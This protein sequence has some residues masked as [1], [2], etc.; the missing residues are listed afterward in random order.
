MRG[1]SFIIAIDGPAAS[2]KGTLARRLA[3]AFSFAHLDTGLL[4]RA[5]GWSLVSAG[6]A[7]DEVGA[8]TQAARTL[9]PAD[10]DNAALRSDA[11]A[12][13][14]SKVAVIPSVREALLAFQRTFAADPP[15]GTEGAVLDGRDVGTVVC[16]E[17]NV[18]LFITATIEARAGRRLRE[19][20]E[21]GL[22]AIEEVVIAEMRERDRRDSCRASAPLRAAEDAVTIDTSCLDADA[23]FA[24][25][26]DV[27]RA[28]LA[29]WRAG[30]SELN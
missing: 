14:A 24:A 18:K 25:A 12:V 4:Y 26:A 22:T 11:A 29:E 27:V 7:P 13:A 3:D 15:A 19:L 8:A 9:S 1:S 6:I 16:P 23:V 28:R 20:R 5:V 10:L 17:A 2:G 21:R 30:T